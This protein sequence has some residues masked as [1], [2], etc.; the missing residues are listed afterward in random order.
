MLRLPRPVDDTAHDRDA[1]LLRT[2]VARLPGRSLLAQVRLDLL[3]HLLKERRRGATTAGTGRNLRGEA[4]QPQRLQNLLGDL[5]LFGA[6]A[7]RARGEGDADRVA[8]P[9]LKEDRKPG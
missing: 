5:H 6:V 4:P 2:G 7:A 1:Q 8:D 3:R 9:F